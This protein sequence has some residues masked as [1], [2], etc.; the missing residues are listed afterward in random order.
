MRIPQKNTDTDASAAE[1]GRMNKKASRR[2]AGRQV[3][4]LCLPA[5]PL[6]RRLP[7]AVEVAVLVCRDDFC[8]AEGEYGFRFSADG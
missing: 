5:M 3:G 2:V 7:E 4:M 1:I 6:Q 8:A